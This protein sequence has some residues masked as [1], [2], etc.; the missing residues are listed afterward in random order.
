MALRSDAREID[1]VDLLYALADFEEHAC[2]GELATDDALLEF[3]ACREDRYPRASQAAESLDGL[4]VGA[5]R[6]G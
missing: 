2:A 6:Y 3:V 1:D 4:A 5:N